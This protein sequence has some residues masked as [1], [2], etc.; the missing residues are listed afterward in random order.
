[1]KRIKSLDNPTDGLV[2][3]RGQPGVN[4]RSWPNFHNH[5]GGQPYREI[6]EALID[7]QHGLCAYCEIDLVEND[8]QVEHVIPRRVQPVRTLD[9]ENMIACCRGGSAENQFG[10]AVLEQHRDE[11]RSL[12][13]GNISCG[14]AKDDRTEALDPRMLPTQPSLFRVRSNGEIDADDSACVAVGI[15]ADNVRETIKILGLNVRRLRQAREKHRRF[16]TDAIRK[17]LS[18]LGNVPPE[19]RLRRMARQRLLPNGNGTLRRLFTTERTVFLPLGG[20]SI[21]AELPQSWI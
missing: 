1:M 3:Y 12:P 21:L 7:L 17:N 6:R 14:Q 20:E 19:R 8:R 5:D 9:H 11:E 15:P 16:L 13:P 10:P 4:I 18:A 2:H